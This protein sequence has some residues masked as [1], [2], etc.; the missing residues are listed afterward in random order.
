MNYVH[1]DRAAIIAR[2]WARRSLHRGKWSLAEL[3]SWLY[4]T[5]KKS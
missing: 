3:N 4:L 5:R 1:M 2:T